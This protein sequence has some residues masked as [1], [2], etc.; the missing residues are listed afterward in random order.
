MFELTPFRRLSP[1]ASIFNPFR[2]LED[3]EK[4]FFKGASLSEFRTDIRDNGDAFLLESDLPGFKKEDIKID[5]EGDYLTISAE[6]R[7]EFEEQDKKGNYI[8]CERSYG[9]YKRSFDISEI[10]AD[11]ISAEYA[12]GVLKLSMPKK[13][14]VL[15]ASK[16]LEIK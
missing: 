15:P 13:Q 9:S 7:S 8:R 11:K 2:E 5:I 16:R 14:A 3:M 4:L 12:D 10:E 6:R 1:A